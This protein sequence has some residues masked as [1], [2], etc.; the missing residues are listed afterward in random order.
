MSRNVE[1]HSARYGQA[2]RKHFET[3]L[4]G[5]YTRAELN[6]ALRSSGIEKAALIESD[7][8]HLIIERRGETDPN[9]WITAREQYR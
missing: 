8:R 2:M 1:E 6:D 5:A 7:D 4:R 9:S 3:A